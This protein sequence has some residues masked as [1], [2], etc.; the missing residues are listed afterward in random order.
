MAICPI[1]STPLS[2]KTVLR[3]F[4]NGNARVRCGKCL[5]TLVQNKRE[6]LGYYIFLGVIVAV[7]S[8]SLALLRIKGPA[9][10]VGLGLLILAAAL[11]FL[12]VAKFKNHNA[13]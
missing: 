13:P 7:S 2:T 11:V 10:F 3:V 6:M 1:C 4:V 5:S 12:K 9:M 8:V